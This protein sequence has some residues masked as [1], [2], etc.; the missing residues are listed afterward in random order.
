MTE[1]Q[2]ISFI[3][4]ALRSKSRFWKPLSDTITQARTKRGFYLCNGCNQEIPKSILVNGK[5][6]NNVYC[7]HRQPV[8]DTV[9]GFIGWDNYINRLFSEKE[10]FQILC[11]DCHTNV[12]SKTEREERKTI[13]DLRNNNEGEYQT[14][15]NMNDRCSNPNATGYQYYGAKGITVCDR[16][17]RNGTPEPFKNFLTD[18]GVRPQNKT[19]DRIDYTKDY[20][21][22]N[23]RW[24]TSQEQARNTSIN[25]WLEYN[26]ELKIL[27]EWGETLGIKP[28]S[29][30]TRLRRGWTV[31]QALGFEKKP[32]LTYS[33]R[34]TQDDFV[35][36][37]DG[38]ASGKTIR[39]ISEDLEMDESQ[40]SRITSKFSLG[41]APKGKTYELDGEYLTLPDWAKRYNIN[42]EAVIYRLKRGKTLKDALTLPVRDVSGKTSSERMIATERKKRDKNTNG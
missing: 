24:A 27:Q 6:V 40:V 41:V 28:N 39:Q 5:R 7:D 14:W 22:E 16:W 36:I 19:L 11:Y 26:G 23:C 9:E 13:T 4:S 10:N 21:I 18:M 25:N 33:G 2:F 34:L 15:S 37:Q 35:Y 29:I 31:G 20:T 32:K 38:L 12:K 8:V 3:K 17:K 30:L 42:Y 1:S